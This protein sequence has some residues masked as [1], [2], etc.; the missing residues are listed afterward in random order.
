MHVNLGIFWLIAN[1]QSSSVFKNVL[2]SEAGGTQP[3]D[4]PPNGQFDDAGFSLE[5]PI[6]VTKVLDD[7]EVLIEEI[8]FMLDGNLEER[9]CGGVNITQVEDETSLLLQIFTIM[10]DEELEKLEND[11]TKLTLNED[12]IGLLFQVLS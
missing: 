7:V 3:S 2:K 4:L 9:K 8:M 11:V 5:K 12:D 10:V 1:V 6:N